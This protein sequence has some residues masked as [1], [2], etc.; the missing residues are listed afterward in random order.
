MDAPQYAHTSGQQ[1]LKRAHRTSNSGALLCSAS[2]PRNAGRL[3]ANRALL[4]YLQKK[5]KRN[6]A[7]REKTHRYQHA[8]RVTEPP[9][10]SAD[11]QEKRRHVG[12]KELQPDRSGG[13]NDGKS[14]KSSTCHGCL[15]ANFRGVFCHP[16][17]KIWRLGPECWWAEEYYR[18]SDYVRDIS[19]MPRPKCRYRIRGMDFAKAAYVCML[20]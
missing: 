1:E 17:G 20:K 19:D 8:R 6:E 18:T 10:S 4:T 14:T 5:G 7:Q 13:N 3:D 2:T 11:P 12:R 16:F 9:R 15:C